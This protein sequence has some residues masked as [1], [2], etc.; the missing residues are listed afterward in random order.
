M[1]A[2]AERLQKEKQKEEQELKDNIFGAV[3]TCFT[4]LMTIL[5]NDH[6]YDMREDPVAMKLAA[7]ESEI[8]SLF[9]KDSIKVPIIDYA[10]YGLYENGPLEDTIAEYKKDTVTGIKVLDDYM[11]KLQGGRCTI[12]KNGRFFACHRYGTG[13]RRCRR[14]SS[15]SDDRHLPHCPW[16]CEYRGCDGESRSYNREIEQQYRKM[17]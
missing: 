16:L 9:K 6:G 12:F 17:E 1:L 13:K 5:P 8:D 2:E 10:V 7:P 4:N 14:E 11:L 15:R 3:K